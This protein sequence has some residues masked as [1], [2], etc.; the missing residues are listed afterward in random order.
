MLSVPRGLNVSASLATVMFAAG[1]FMLLLG[2]YLVLATAEEEDITVSS[3]NTCHRLM[4]KERPSSCKKI[5]IPRGLCVE[6][7]R[8]E[9]YHDGRFKD[10][11]R[12]F[13]IQK[14]SCQ[15]KLQEY[16]MLDSCDFPRI[17]ALLMFQNSSDNNEEEKEEG[18]QILD[19]L[20]HTFCEGGC[21]CIPMHGADRDKPEISIERGNCQAHMENDLWYDASDFVERSMVFFTVDILIFLCAAL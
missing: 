12:T 6:C 17:D 2:S 10:C 8:D 16:A 18:R 5:W 14:T 20:A 9:I 19:F 1:F 15:D 21:D 3:I 13:E 7:T 11:T 4:W